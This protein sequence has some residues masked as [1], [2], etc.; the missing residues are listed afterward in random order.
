M[1]GFF[2]FYDHYSLRKIAINFQLKY[3]EIISYRNGSLTASSFFN[4]IVKENK[5]KCKK[6][7]GER[8]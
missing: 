5:S 1:S 2:L 7:F 4:C 6:M 8:I 3:I